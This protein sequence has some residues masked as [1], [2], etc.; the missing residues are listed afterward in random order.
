MDRF[1]RLGWDIVNVEAL[2]INDNGIDDA[3]VIIGRVITVV[4]LLGGEALW[5]VFGG[6]IKAFTGRC[7]TESRAKI[8]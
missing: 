3:I 6:C 4:E 8:R 1:S 5:A 7:S 2:S